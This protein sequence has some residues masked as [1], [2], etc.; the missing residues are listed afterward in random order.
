MWRT[1]TVKANGDRRFCSPERKENRDRNLRREPI[2]Q[3]GGGADARAA[4]ERSNEVGII[5]FK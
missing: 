4:G 3:G 2:L 1:E 5:L